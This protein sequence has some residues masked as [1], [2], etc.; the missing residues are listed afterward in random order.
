MAAYSFA[1]FITYK[2]MQTVFKE[3]YL[4]DLAL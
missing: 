3:E 2:S 1:G 4:V